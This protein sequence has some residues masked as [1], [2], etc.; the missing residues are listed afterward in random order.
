M[1]KTWTTA[2][3]L[4]CAATA[5]AAAYRNYA[6]TP[7]DRQRPADTAAQAA[8]TQSGVAPARNGFSATAAA[9]FGFSAPVTLSLGLSKPVAMEIGDV[10]G[11]GLAD[12]V[13]ST[14]GYDGVPVRPPPRVLVYPQRA[15]GG[16]G[17]PLSLDYGSDGKYFGTLSLGDLNDDGILDI[18]AGRNTGVTLF[19]AD[20]QGGFERRL[21]NYGSA[22]ALCQVAILDAN[23]DGKG[24]VACH[25]Y[26][27]GTAVLIGDGQGGIRETWTVPATSAPQYSY[28]AAADVNDDGVKDLI[29]NGVFGL[30]NFQVIPIAAAGGFDVA[31]SYVIT[32]GGGSAPVRF[33]D[34][35]GDGRLDLITSSQSVRFVLNLHYQ[36]EAGRLPPVS[37]LPSID[38]QFAAEAVDL[39]RDGQGDAIAALDGE[40]G[41]Y[42]QD[43][44][45]FGPQ[46]L[47]QAF[48]PGLEGWMGTRVVAGDLDGDG[49]TDAVVGSYR[50]GDLTLLYGRNCKPAAPLRAVHD[51]DGDG[52]SD[53]LWRNDPASHWAYWTMSGAGKRGG[54]SY[55]V[56]PSWRVLATGDFQGDGRTDL[57]WSD[58]ASTQM[59]KGEAGGFVGEVMPAPP[60]GQR[61]LAVGDIDSDGKS[62]LIWQDADGRSLIAWTQDG[63][64]T[65]QS[66]R[67]AL[68]SPWRVIGSGDLNGDRRLDLVCSDGQRM[69]LWTNTTRL[70]FER[71]EMGAYPQDWDLVG[72][73]DI[74]GD[75]RS[76]LF[77]RNAAAGAF[78]TWNM[79]G[80][81]RRSGA[82]YWVGG[83]WRVLD[84]GD[85]DG[86]GRTDLVWTDGENMQLWA[87]S[88]NGFAGALMPAYPRGWSLLP[89]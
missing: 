16:L 82:T 30:H 45:R 23:L 66:K 59:W 7:A 61:V 76:D 17:E 19:L 22:D 12:L 74:D 58:G 47:I 72:S 80:A 84:S 42:L 89:R 53:L 20:G 26:E 68:P 33:G 71:R 28:I 78:V 51:I 64:R 37:F 40:V 11:D 52:R 5:A 3:A 39:D 44:G 25:N 49:C 24:D 87:A 81:H 41:Y 56:G 54:L 73:G 77:W 34:L 63:A 29:R 88:G 8:S 15:Q 6:P 70:V 35:N 43:A 1:Q 50:N 69:Q 36:N 57:I 14:F 4:A 46:Q 10:T 79:V 55:A 83:G 62:D 13:V 85:F 60:A 38:I 2:L 32:E 18:A 31:G 75:G 21:H 48:P 86:D 27:A 65:K 9:P 67:Y